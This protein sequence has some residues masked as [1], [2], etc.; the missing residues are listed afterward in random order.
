[1]KTALVRT[2]VGASPYVWKLW[3]VPIVKI[4]VTTATRASEARMRPNP[5]RRSRSAYSPARQ[6]TSTVITVRNGSQSVSTL[7]RRPHWET[8]LP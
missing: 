4:S 3:P 2:A 8:S 5:A 7:Q 1:M 6:K